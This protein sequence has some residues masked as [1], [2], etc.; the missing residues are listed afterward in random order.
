MEPK[1]NFQVPVEGLELYKALRHHKSIINNDS[2]SKFSKLFLFVVYHFFTEKI[3]KKFTY[4]K[5]HNFSEKNPLK[6]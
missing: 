4:K 3:L 2:H 1:L 6:A 5:E